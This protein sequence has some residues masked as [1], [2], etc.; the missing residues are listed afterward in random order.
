VAAHLEPEILIIDE[1]LAVGDIEFQKKCLTKMENVSDEGRTILFVSHNLVA[2]KNLCKRGLVLQNGKIIYSGNTSDAIN[3]YLSTYRKVSLNNGLIPQNHSTHYT[4]EAKFF[5]FLMLDE[6][7]K[8]TNMINLYEPIRLSVEIDASTK[9]S[10]GMI[11]IKIVSKD[12]VEVV[13][14][15]NH[16]DN[17]EFNIGSGRY[18]L[19]IIIENLLQP[20]IYAFTLGVHH[21]TG[22]TIDYVESIHEFEIQMASNK[23]QPSLRR[24]LLHGYVQAPAK[25]NLQS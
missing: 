14:S 23:S 24:E 10:N 13:H 20:G 12:G 16:Y 8:P 25:W 3:N 19:D 18:T 7:Q 4:G 5:R 2:V 9:I 11:D 17:Y 6:N 1:V 22:H 21:S 15:M